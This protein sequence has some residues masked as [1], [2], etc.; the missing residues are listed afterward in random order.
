MFCAPIHETL[1]TRFS[2]LDE[3]IFSP[4]N[5]FIRFILRS[6]FFTTSTFIAAMMPFLGDFVNLSGSLCVTPLTFIF[7]SL[8]YLKVK[9]QNI[10]LAEKIWHWL[11][12]I[13]FSFITVIT[14]ASA[15]HSIVDN[16]KTYHVFANT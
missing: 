7:P 10:S 16:A 8:I 4:H 3:K 1:D 12:I 2:R 13:I 9:G 5:V 11:N 6:S 14:T 15:I